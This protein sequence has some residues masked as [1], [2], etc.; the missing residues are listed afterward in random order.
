ML[1]CLNAATQGSSGVYAK[2]PTNVRITSTASF[3]MMPLD[4]LV[5]GE[6]LRPFFATHNRITEH[7]PDDD[8]E[9]GI[10]LAH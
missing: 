5:P 4:R 1:D 9:E 6:G 10:P 2:I 8:E 3:P 7:E